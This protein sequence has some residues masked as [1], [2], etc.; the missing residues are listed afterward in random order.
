MPFLKQYY[1]SPGQD[2]ARDQN[3]LQ[4]HE[5][6]IYW[7]LFYQYG[8]YSKDTAY[9]DWM[10]G[11]LLLA[12][13]GGDFL[14]GNSTLLGLSGRWND[15]I[16]WWALAT[17]TAAEHYGKDAII[18]PNQP[19]NSNPTYFGATH[20]T[21]LEMLDQ[22]DSSTCGGGMF[23]SRNRNS[24]IENQLFYKSTISNAE[25]LDLG[26][27][28]YTLTKDPAYLDWFD[29]VY[30]WLKT[31]NLISPTYAVYDGLD[32][33]SC[34]INEAQYSY[35][36]AE[37]ISGLAILHKATGNPTYLTEAHAHFSHVQSFFVNN[38][39][40]VLYD[41][42]GGDKTPTGFLWSLYRALATLYTI[43]TNTDVKTRIATVLRMSAAANFQT[44]TY[45]WNCITKLSP[46]PAK[47]TL[48]DGT[49][50][51]AQM[52]SVAILN[53]LA[54]VNGAPLEKD[55]QQTVSGAVGGGVAAVEPKSG[56]TVV[57]AN[58]FSLVL[59]GA[60]LL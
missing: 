21:Y 54:V 52:E 47:Y 51:R 10:D 48:P 30:N 43:T 1:T 18:A 44:C 55:V 50:V 32:T 56:G 5:S 35:H 40:G 12:T 4:W 29:R 34:Q 46:V 53:A 13:V 33:R 22:W 28:L 16:G 24:N 15:D 31:S 37:L 2:G 7:D 42:Q 17:M 11:E 38:A 9:N 39:T 59:V 23:W 58:V 19:G 14:D 41:P 60:F 36:S 8:S 49:N 3:H 6:A 26:A 20:M 25:H 57:A 45:E 27:R